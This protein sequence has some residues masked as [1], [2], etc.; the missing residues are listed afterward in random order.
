[1]SGE[2]YGLP[3]RWNGRWISSFST[4]W[5]STAATLSS[6]TADPEL[7]HGGSRVQPRRIPSTAT[8]DPELIH[9]GSR[10]HHGESRAHHGGSR[11]QPRRIPSSST[12]DPELIH[13]GSRAQPRRILIPSMIDFITSF[14]LII[15]PI[16]PLLIFFYWTLCIRF[17]HLT[18]YNWVKKE[19]E[20]VIL[21]RKKK[22]SL[23]NELGEKKSEKLKF[24]LVQ[25]C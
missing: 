15:T 21:S 16:N 1:M 7:I 22:K 24:S 6:A 11:A 2:F 18:K 17:E 5:Y 20:F 14:G 3:R 8:A 4:L 25:G 23:R 9:G 19:D 10:A 13:G 12:V